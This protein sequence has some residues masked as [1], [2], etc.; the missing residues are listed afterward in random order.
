VLR[1]IGVDRMIVSPDADGGL[2]PTTGPSVV[3]TGLGVPRHPALE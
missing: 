2:T 1:K 3:R